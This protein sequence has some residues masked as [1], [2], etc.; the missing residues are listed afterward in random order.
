MQ[1]CQATPTSITSRGSDELIWASSPQGI[2]ELRS[3]YKLAMGFEDSTPFSAS[4]IWKMDTLPRI[5]TFLWMCAHNSIGVKVYL[6][7]RGIAQET[8]CPIY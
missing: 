1:V 6:Q 7:R 2:F 4:W 5:K 8:I 3:A